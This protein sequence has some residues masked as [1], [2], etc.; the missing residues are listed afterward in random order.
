MDQAQT[1]LKN[2][3]V[4]VWKDPFLQGHNIASVSNV[5]GG[6]SSAP[7]DQNY[8]NMVWYSTLIQTRNKNYES[9]VSEKGK[10]TAETSNPLTIEKPSDLM[11]KIL[12][13]VFKKEFHN[14]KSR[15]ASNYSVVEYLAQTPCAMSALEVLQSFP[16][17]QD[18]L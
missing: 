12:K 7:P 1:L 8:I 9:E 3:Q 4:D 2:Q 16:T 17:Q 6:T 14:P 18:A 11:L 13:G 15:A 5:A 10:S